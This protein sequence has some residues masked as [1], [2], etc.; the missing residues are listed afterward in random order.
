M[1]NPE[2]G[3]SL[4]G[5]GSFDPV[6]EIMVLDEASPVLGAMHTNLNRAPGGVRFDLSLFTHAVEIDLAGSVLSK[7]V[8]G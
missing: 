5:A 2:S 1:L 8:T 6:C 4:E 3:P 7:S